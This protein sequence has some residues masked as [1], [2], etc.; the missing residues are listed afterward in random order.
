M[1]R[2]TFLQATLNQT[3][4][5]IQTC[6]RNVTGDTVEDPLNGHIRLCLY[7]MKLTAILSIVFGSA[8]LC[9]EFL[10]RSILNVAYESC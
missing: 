3:K 10:G 6:T 4:T 5:K 8:L 9:I 7:S 1:R 2:N